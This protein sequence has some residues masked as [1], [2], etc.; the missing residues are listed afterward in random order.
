MRRIMIIGGPG[1]GKS[2]LARALGDALGLPVHHIDALFW[3]PGWVEGDR[4][5]LADRLRTIYATEAWVIEGNY[6][7]TWPERIA[8]ADTVVHLDLPV[9]LRLL[10][11]LWRIVSGYGRVRAD[12]APDCPE[13][14]DPGFLPY[15]VGYGRKRRPKALALL[16]AAPPQVA[17]HRLRSRGA[18]RRFLATAVAS[19]SE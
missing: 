8:R 3:Q 17:L 12:M 6:S 10:R 13:Q 7:A 2:S 1:A 15:L 5:V 18:V 11:V 4:S 19:Q 16:E 9:P 14:L